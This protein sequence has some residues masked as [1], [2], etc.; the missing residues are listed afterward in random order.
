MSRLLVIDEC[1]STRVATELNGRRRPAKSTASLDLKQRTDPL[2]IGAVEALAEDATLVT[3][4]DHMP[5]DHGDS[6]KGSQLA[7]AIVDPDKPDG[8][9]FDEWEKDVIHRWAH[10]MQVQEAG[11]IVRYNLSGGRT[12]KRPRSHR[13]LT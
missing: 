6:L 9:D 11:T 4:N 2:V 12:W 13:R 8:F 3:A 10:K 5:D 7:V 1:L